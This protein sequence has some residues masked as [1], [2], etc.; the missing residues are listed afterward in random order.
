MSDVIS[1]AD[2]ARRILSDPLY[3]EAMETIKTQMRDLFFVGTQT[4][5]QREMLHLMDQARERFQQVFEMAIM[6]AEIER[7]H[8]IEEEQRKTRWESIMQRLR[9]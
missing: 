2:Q 4:A 7:H 9:G 5:E 8:L 1:R 6:G 3:V